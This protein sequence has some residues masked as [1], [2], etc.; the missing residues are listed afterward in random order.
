MEAADARLLSAATWF[1]TN[2]KLVL[3]VG[4]PCLVFVLLFSVRTT[5]N[6]I[7]AI[8]ATL[9][10]WIAFWLSHFV[11]LVLQLCF[12]CTIGWA[13]PLRI[14]S[15]ILGRCHQITILFLMTL[16]PFWWVRVCRRPKGGIPKGC[17]IMPN[18]LSYVDSWIVASAVF[19]VAP[20]FIAMEKL[21]KMPLL[22]SVM[23]LAG[24]IPVPFAKKPDGT[25][26]IKEGA[27]AIIKE[28]ARAYLELGFRLVVFPEGSLS[29]DGELKEF[30]IGMFQVAF[31]A[32]R[33]IVPIGMW[34]NAAMFPP[35]D[36]YA[37]AHAARVNLAIGDPIQ[38]TDFGS[39]EEFRDAVKEAV[40]ALR[41]GLPN[42]DKSKLTASVQPGFRQLRGNHNQFG[43]QLGFHA[44]V[45]IVPNFFFFVVA[46][47]V[48]TATDFKFQL[49][50][51]TFAGRLFA[52]APL[53]RYR[54][55]ER[56]AISVNVQ[57]IRILL[58][59]AGTGRRPQFCPKEAV[60]QN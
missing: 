29:R 16:N 24:H 47:V 37:M 12:L 43:R 27:G 25:I 19:P 39:A 28:S 60:L 8:F 48:I 9:Y 18:H 35:G 5:R 11:C 1:E 3:S 10:L 41:D 42:H 32:G 45:I 17:I 51:D 52:G 53:S 22:G 58:R 15:G 57:T 36:Q 7:L 40:R 21:F 31:D 14:R 2:L 38:S 54:R 46:V 34:G 56:F 49:S 44:L 13:L 4:V 26:G 20:K 6:R 50:G 33:P 59:F 55:P 23:H 30:K